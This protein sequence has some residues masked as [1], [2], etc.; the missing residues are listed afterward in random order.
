MAKKIPIHP[1]H[2]ERICWG[3][4]HYCHEN[5]MRCGNGQSRTQH[6]IELL[7][8]DWYKHGDWNIELP[9]DKASQPAPEP[10][11]PVEARPKPRIRLKMDKIEQ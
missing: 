7:G 5:A 6:P 1:L 2:P 4:D 3:C 9:E 8:A 11:K 10:E